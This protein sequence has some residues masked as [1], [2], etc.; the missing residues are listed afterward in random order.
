MGKWA[1]NIWAELFFK[2]EKAPGDRTF[3][4]QWVRCDSPGIKMFRQESSL[5]GKETI[6]ILFA[7]FSIFTKMTI[8]WPRTPSFW[9]GQASLDPPML[10]R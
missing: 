2:N 6:H 9:P 5:R 4:P 7:I 8:S 10:V 3:L 1:F